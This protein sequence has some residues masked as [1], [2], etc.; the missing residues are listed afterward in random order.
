VRLLV[1]D[2]HEIVRMGVRILL[3]DTNQWD[4]CGEAESGVEAIQKAQELSPDV[5]ILDLSMPVMRGFETARWEVA[6]IRPR[7]EA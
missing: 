1:V 6:A 7:P 2:G 3:S 4:I 5:V